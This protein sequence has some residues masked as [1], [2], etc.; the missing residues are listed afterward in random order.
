MIH[1]QW[2]FQKFIMDE[3]AKKPKAKDPLKTI[4]YFK[5]LIAIFGV[6]I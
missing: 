6:I 3:E 4:G 2:Y 1:L 5:D